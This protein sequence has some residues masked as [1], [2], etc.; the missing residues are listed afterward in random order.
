[1]I[2]NTTILIPA[3]NSLYVSLVAALV[4]VIAALPVTILVVSLKEIE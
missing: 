3:R 1:M 2:K 4:T